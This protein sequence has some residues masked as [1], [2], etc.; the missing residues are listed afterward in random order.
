MKLFYYL[1]P[2]SLFVASCSDEA[3]DSMQQPQPSDSPSA[4]MLSPEAMFPTSD[5]STLLS[6][7]PARAAW[8]ILGKFDPNRALDMSQL[9][10]TNEQ[11]AE[12]KQFVD[13]HFKAD[14]QYDTY[15]NIFKWICSNIKYAND[16]DAYLDPYDV[17][18]HKRCIC[19]GYANLLKTMCYTQGIPCLIANGMLS[20]I[21]GHAWN[22]VYT[23]GQ[24]YVS[25]PTNND[26]YKA[27]AYTSYQ[28]KLI[29]QQ[30]DVILFEDDHFK[31]SF[32][33]KQINVAEVK[34]TT[35]SYVVLPYGTNGLRVTC[36]FP[37]KQLP[38]NIETLYIGSNIS[39][40][41]DYPDGLN[42]LT[43]NLREVVVD[44][45]NSKFMSYKGVVY[46]RPSSTTPYFVPAGIRRLELRPMRVMDK[47]VVSWLK[48]VEEIVIAQGTTRIE[49]YAIEG[50]PNLKRVYV[51]ESVTYIAPNAFYNCGEP[52]IVRFTTGITEV[53][54]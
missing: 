51:P 11:L 17:F 54:M 13:E 10:I 48:N 33:N 44:T 21:G 14:T 3:T 53:T 52:E 28:N 4:P 45:K 36:F 46:Q 2:L 25:D 39:S 41:S 49:D 9:Q 34:P 50:C 26:Q 32:Y 30:F 19:Q 24:W 6:T 47:N 38:E 42:A 29:P 31:Y 12:I 8:Q 15:R 43:P 23:D 5:G 16:G 20:T 37:Q 35:D 27:S 7:T 18:V 40:F 1:L 22:Y